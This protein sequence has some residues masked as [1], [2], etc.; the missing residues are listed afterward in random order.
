[1]ANDEH[2][3][4]GEEQGLPADAAEAAEA[5][6]HAETEQLDLDADE[7]RL[8]WLESDEDYQEDGVDTARLLIFAVIGLIVIALIVGG[9]WWS[10]R[11]HGPSNTLADG[12]TIA[13]PK[14]PYKTKPAEPGGK[15]FQGTGD[16]SFAV[17]EGQS[18]EGQLAPGETPKP[19]V[20]AATPA[21]TQASADEGVGVQVGAFSTR[22]TAIQGWSKLAGQFAVLKGMKYRV[23]EGQADIG[24][25]YRLQ[26]V[27]SD[28]A[29]ANSLCA[30]LKASGG[31]CQV[32]P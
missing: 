12:S 10:T 32:K 20:D 4:E 22:A 5:Y 8:P 23:I 21:N 11:E 24:T 19:N 29:A 28:L 3:Y 7:G 16:E 15:T 6:D 27:A 30:S 18:R 2:G 14:T 17:A 31:A 26:A 1:M 25:V 9:I 13:A